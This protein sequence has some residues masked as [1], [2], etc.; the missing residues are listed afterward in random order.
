MRAPE[1]DRVEAPG[2]RVYPPGERVPAEAR[3]ATPRK[4]APGDGPLDAPPAPPVRLV[5]R[6]RIDLLG[7]EV[8]S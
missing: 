1:R 3:P 6:R 4:C 7:R 2:L 5:G 8:R